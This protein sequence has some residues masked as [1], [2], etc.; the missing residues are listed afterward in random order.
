MDNQYNRLLLATINP[1]EWSL[2]IYLLPHRNLSILILFI[3]TGLI[4]H[5]ANNF[6]PSAQTVEAILAFLL[7]SLWGELSKHC[8]LNTFQRV[9]VEY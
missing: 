8:V 3:E 9:P 5:T 7:D 4:M 2:V 1:Q 6:S